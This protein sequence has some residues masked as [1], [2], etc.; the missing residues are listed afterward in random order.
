MLFVQILGQKAEPIAGVDCFP[1]RGNFPPSLWEPGVIYRDR[2]VLPLAPDAQAPV[3]AA[4]HVGL[5]WQDGPRLTATLPSGERAPDPLWFDLVPVRSAETPSKDTVYPVGAKLGEAITLVG[6]DL[7]SEEV[8]PGEMVTVTLVW[9]ADSVPEA[10]YT[11]FVHLFDDGD[12]VAQDDHPP[13]YGEYR[14]SFWEPVDVVRDTY[15]LTLGP[16]QA[17]CNCGL[18]VG[19]YDPAAGVRL[20]AYDGLGG[21]FENDAV[22][23]GGV[24]VR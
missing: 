4:L 1:G 20:P 17:P 10:D 18:Q 19:M 24:I 16:D 8:Q 9:Q 21:R 14:T 11:V 23:A 6:Y 2:Y 5:H 12:L 22:V 15:V 3:I 13:L 7:A